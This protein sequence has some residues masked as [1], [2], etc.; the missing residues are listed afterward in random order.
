[1]ATSLSTVDESLSDLRM[2]LRGEALTPSDPGY[3]RARL[4]FNAMHTDRPGVVVRPTGTT[5][6][7]EAAN[8]ARETDDPNNFFPRNNN[9]LPAG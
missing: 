1:M 3:D 6:V 7:L 4:P 8:F 5:D 2:R 9:L